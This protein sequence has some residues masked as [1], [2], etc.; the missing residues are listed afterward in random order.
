MR[1]Y[2]IVEK[3]REK[4]RKAKDR[5]A[6]FNPIYRKLS[7]EEAQSQASR[8]LQCPIDVLRGLDS[9]FSFCRTGCPLNNQI[10]GWLKK[11]YYG[12]V[13]DAFDL[14][15]EMSPFPEI[16]GRVCPKVGLCESSC[17]IE[18]S[19]YDAVTIGEVETY[20]NEKAFDEGIIPFYGDSQNRKHKVAIVGSGPA[21]MS[22]ATFLLRAGINVEIFEK[23]DR[24]GGLLTYGIPNFKLPKNAVER[25]YSWMEKAGLKIHTNV[26]VGKDIS[27]KKLE[28]EFDCIFLG[29]GAPEGRS[30]KMENEYTN[31]VYHVMDI[32]T[33]T[34][35]R[36]FN[37]NSVD[38]ILEDKNVVVIGG[39]DSAMDALRTAI[40]EEANNVT[41]IYRRDE[42]GMPGSKKEVI[43]AKE[44][45]VDFIFNRQ[46]KRVLVD[47]KMNV[48][49]IEAAKT[50]L[51]EKDNAGKTTLNILDDEIIQIEADIII[52]ALGFNN[53]VFDFYNDL[54]LETGKYND[55][56]VN[57]KKETT[58]KNIYAGGDVARGAD[59]V[60]TAALDGRTAA[61]AIVEKLKAQ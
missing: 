29:M 27:I 22:C 61:M 45:G 28:E 51:G 1:K 2:S 9:E 43:N 44:E 14:S 40:R 21:G 7:D 50:E 39:G 18:K 37:K 3:K 5:I 32:L 35:K 19:K 54:G 13:K 34:Q 56:L 20:L 17:V 38:S 59:L 33:H 55:I 47:E 58:H 49:G 23:E 4:K 31:G 30:A 26:E 6:D 48:V 16:L 57:D 46:P 8:C 25:R 15:N 42:N 53:K 24:V 36:I 12:E 60:V 10:S 52:L 11:T 41:C